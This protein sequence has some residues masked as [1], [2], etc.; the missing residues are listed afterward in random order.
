[1]STFRLIDA[2]KANYPVAKLCRMLGVSKSGYYAWRGRPP[3][4]RRCED[5]S[6]TEKIRE[7]HSRSRETYGYPRVHAELRSLGVRC[8]RRRVAR[9]MRAAGLRG[10]MRGKKR[11]TTRRDPRAAPAPD[12]LRRDF[13]AGEP[14]KIWLADITYVPT[15]EGFL[16]LAFILDTHSRKIVGWSM[17]S[18]MRTELVVDALEM[19]LWRR[20][21]SAGLTHHTD[22]GSQLRFNRSSQHQ[23][24]EVLVW[25]D[26]RAGPHGSRDERPY[27]LQG[28]RGSAI[29]ASASESSGRPSL[30]GSAARM[31]ERVSASQVQSQRGGSAILAG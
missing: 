18:H 1:M 6:L 26:H 28:L 25:D 11:R 10:C 9:L 30:R 23:P 29:S 2:E 7:I 5:S 14:N 27:V 24:R 31:L 17:D 8:G 19:A 21:P 4:K 22:R 16:Y 3:S 15:R 13:M 20:K 12:L